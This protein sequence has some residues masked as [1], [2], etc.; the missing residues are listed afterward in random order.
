MGDRNETRI[1]RHLSLE[2]QKLS[3]KHQLHGKMD[4][5]HY[6]HSLSVVVAGSAVHFPGSRIIWEMDLWVCLRG[7]PWL[8]SLILE[9][10]SY[11]QVTSLPS[12][13]GVF[14]TAKMDTVSDLSTRVHFNSAEQKIGSYL[15]SRSSYP[16]IYQSTTRFMN[17]GNRSQ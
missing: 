3:L 1:K 16:G 7:S 11:L 13:T 14:K 10:P 5:I 4:S 17:W 8:C 12:R 15:I 2:W 9:D 6:W